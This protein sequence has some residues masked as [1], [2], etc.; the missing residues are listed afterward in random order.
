MRAQRAESRPQPA[1]TVDWSAID[2]ADLASPALYINREL[3][4]LEFN[5]RVLAQAQDAYHPLLERVKFL[6]I[7]ASNLDEF[8]MVRVATILKKFRA[9]IDDVSIDG[10]NT[11]DELAV[12]RQRALAQMHLQSA[13]W[14]TSLRP[15][16]AAG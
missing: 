16:L 15:L 11:E 14:S 10:L 4:W 7:T 2:S 8:F 9:D 12:I 5:Q 6:A 13:C 3:S 1:P